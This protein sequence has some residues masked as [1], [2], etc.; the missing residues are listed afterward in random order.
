M[1]NYNRT[2][3]SFV[4]EL[5]SMY[6]PKPGTSNTSAVVVSSVIGTVR[7]RSQAPAAR[8]MIWEIPPRYETYE[9]DVPTRYVDVRDCFHRACAV[10]GTDVAYVTCG[11]RGYGEEGGEA[12]VQSRSNSA[13]AAV[14]C[15]RWGRYVP[16]RAVPCAYAE[17]Y[18]NR[19]VELYW[20]GGTA[21]LKRLRPG[22]G[23]LTWG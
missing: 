12:A 9:M 23:V 2:R 17:Q 22:C 3:D 6:A 16:T 13:A 15:T 10:S 14:R 18:C 21:V 5:L 19:G 8:S 7:Y 1:Q 20:E 4:E 11:R